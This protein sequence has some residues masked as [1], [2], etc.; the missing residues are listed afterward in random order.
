MSLPTL[1]L[2][3]FFLGGCGIWAIF[4][5]VFIELVTILLPFDILVFRNVGS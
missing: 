1:F 2:K 4:F 5:K 3:R